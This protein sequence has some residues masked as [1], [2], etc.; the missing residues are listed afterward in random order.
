MLSAFLGVPV[1]VNETRFGGDANK[2]L[3]SDFFASVYVVH[4]STKAAVRRQ[5]E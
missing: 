4:N 2:H 3:A 1:R 5:S